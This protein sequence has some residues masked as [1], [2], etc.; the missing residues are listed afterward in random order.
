[1]K[2]LN[3]RIL[4]IVFTM[5]LVTAS[6][7]AQG[8]VIYNSIP[9]PMPGNLA[10]QPFQAQQA[11]EVGDRLQFASGGRSVLTVTQTM[12]SWACQSGSWYSGDCVTAANATFTHPITLNLYN[13]GVGNAVGSLIASVEQT[14][15]IP[16]R[17]SADPV[18]CTGANAGK[19]YHAASATC[20]NGFAT[21]I[22]FNLTGVTVP[23][24]VI[25]GIAYNTS[26]YGDDP[27]GTMPCSS[28]AEGCPY[29]SLNVALEGVATVGVDPAPDDAYFNTLTA[30]WYC[31]G[32][33][34]GVGTFRLDTG[35]WTGYK[36]MVKFTASNVPTNANQC[37]NGGW[38]TRT[39][40]NGS[41][42][43]NQGDCIQY[44]N[45]GR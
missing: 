37:K 45:T 9:S 18:N 27:I 14:F 39:R 40:A 22:T 41:F 10:S 5:L 2:S 30:A 1:M 28:T 6:A 34:G 25:Y 33:A 24:Q 31:D 15:A 16:Y 12:S 7:F 3:F 13:V 29:D 43:K 26:N 8:Q 36:S 35:C 17:P 4:V 20:F 21:N 44:V 32:G 42:F 11:A 38:R 19:W 23:N